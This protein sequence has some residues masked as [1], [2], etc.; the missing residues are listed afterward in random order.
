MQEEQEFENPFVPTWQLLD[1]EINPAPAETFIG[2]D[3]STLYTQKEYDKIYNLYLQEKNRADEL[4]AGFLAAADIMY[5]MLAYLNAARLF[6]GAEPMMVTDINAIIENNPVLNQLCNELRQTSI[7]SGIGVI[8]EM[9]TSQENLREKVMLMWQQRM[10]NPD[11]RAEIEH[12]LFHLNDDNRTNT[13]K[14]DEI[15]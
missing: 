10:K 1:D 14:G 11:C 9:Q 15:F 12:E 5:E 7:E 2:E 6:H 13:D 3:G 4:L 8:S